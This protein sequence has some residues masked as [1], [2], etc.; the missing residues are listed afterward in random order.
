MNLLIPP[1]VVVALAAAAMWGMDR[2]I[3]A[4]GLPGGLRAPLAI[5]LAAGAASLMAAALVTMMRAKTTFNPLKPETSARLVTHGVFRFSRNPI[6]LADLLLLVA[7]G[8]W[9]G[10]PATLPVLPLF[11]LY[12]A[13]FQIRPEEDALEKLFGEEFRAYRARVRRWI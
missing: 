13:R 7:F 11:V 3:D 12:L 6:Y 8:A 1:P 9:L 4:P 5:A 2:A 10:N